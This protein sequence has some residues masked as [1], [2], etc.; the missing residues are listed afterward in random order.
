[1]TVDNFDKVIDFMKFSREKYSRL[2]FFNSS[3]FR[4]LFSKN[5]RNKN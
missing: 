4:R 2:L 1:M 3:S 5:K